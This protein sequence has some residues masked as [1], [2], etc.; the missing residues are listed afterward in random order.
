LHPQLQL[1][2]KKLL[3]LNQMHKIHKIS[4]SRCYLE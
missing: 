4:Y 1:A 2:N 3:I